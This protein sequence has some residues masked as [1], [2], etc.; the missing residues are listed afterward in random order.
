MLHPLI[1]RVPAHIRIVQTRA[2]FRAAFGYEAPPFDFSQPVKDWL[3][4]RQNLDPDEEVAYVGIRYEANG[5][6]VYDE[7]RTV[8]TREFRLFPEVGQEVNLLPEPLPPQGAMTPLQLR[9]VQRR[10]PWPLVL[11]P[12][13]RVVLAPG[14]GTVPVV[15]DGGTPPAT[16]GGFTERD[17]EL[18]S[19][20]AAKVGA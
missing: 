1:T 12:G 17:R 5:E 3:D 16:P 7:Q 11:S 20:I 4:T 13:E 8:E 6:P 19:A 9:M 18:L 15:D 10:R 14:I 2:A